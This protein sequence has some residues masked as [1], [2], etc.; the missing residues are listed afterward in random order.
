M[1]CEKQIVFRETL[2]CFEKFCPALLSIR[3]SSSKGMSPASELVLHRRDLPSPRSHY[4]GE[5]SSPKSCIE[6]WD[7]EKPKILFTRN[8][9]GI[10]IKRGVKVQ[11]SS[12]SNPLPPDVIPCQSTT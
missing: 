12:L 1:K 11:E 10:G 2:N 9:L 8:D 5:V 4:K 7:F 6:E 3:T